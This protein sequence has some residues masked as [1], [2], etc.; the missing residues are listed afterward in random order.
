MRRLPTQ[1]VPKRAAI[2][3]STGGRDRCGGRKR[4]AGPRQRSLA[5]LF[6][7]ACLCAW[8]NL[9]IGDV[10]AQLTG[11]LGAHDPSTVLYEDGR[12][13]YF[14]TG[15]LLAV[16]SSANLNFWSGEPAALSQV[17]AW[18]PGAVPGYQ[19]QS[20]WAPDVIELGGQYYLYYSASVWGTKLS[21]IGLA[22]S[23]TLDPDAPGYGWTDQGMIINSNHGSPYNAIDPSLLLD[24]ATG[25]LWMTWGSF[26]NGIYVKEM[27]PA[28]GLPLS[29]SPGV[30][31]AAPGPTVEIEGAAM[32]KRGGYYYMFVNWGGCCSGVDSTYNIRVGRSTSPTGP[33][34]DRDGVNMLSGGGT[35]FLDD[36]GRKIAPGHFSFTDV[37]GQDQFSYHYY[38]GDAIGAPTFALRDLYWTADDWPSI[39]AVNPEWATAADGDW[40]LPSRWTN[41]V[42]PDGVGHVANFAAGAGS[43]QYLS[44]DLGGADRTVGTLNFRSVARYFIG[45]AAGPALT[46]DDVAGES[47]TINVS[48]GLPVIG[49]P[50]TALDRLEVNVTPADGELTLNGTVNGPG[51]RK[52]GDGEL[53]LAGAN[54]TFSDSIFV[55]NGS[56]V[57]TG[58]VTGN[59][60]NSIGQIL[61]ETGELSVEGTGQFISNGDLN[62]G[63]TGNNSTPATGTLYVSDQANVVVGA[64]GGLYVGSGFSANTRAE[65]AVVQT[66]G[67]LSVN[68]PA[69][70]SFIVG[71]RGSSAANG[72]YQ[73]S[74]GTVFANT[75]VFIG[76]RGQGTVDQTGGDFNASQFVAIARYAGSTGNWTIRGGAL[77][78]TNAATWLLVG[79]QGQGEL[80]LAGA[81]QV[82]ASGVVRLGHQSSGAGAINL[83]G[84]TLTA[85][86][87]VRGAGSAVVNLNGGILRA[88]GSH[89]SFLQGLT[90]VNV[91]AGGAAV[92]TQHFSVTIAQP[93]LHAAALGATPDGGLTK[94]GS[95]TLTL[96]AA[97][98]YTGPTTVAAGTLRAA[99][100]TGSATGV[101]DVF[102]ES[103]ATLSGT[104]AVAGGVTI[105]TG[106]TLA[107][108]DSPG[109]LSVGSVVL[110]PGAIFAVELAGHGGVAGVGFDQL[111][112]SGDASLAGLLSVSL[113]PGFVPTVGDSFE[114]LNVGGTR[115]G[116]FAGSGQGD[117]VGVWGSIGLLIDYAAGDGNDVALLAQ[118]LLPGDY[119]FDSDADG[120][121]FLLWQR[122]ESSTPLSPSDLA[123]WQANYGASLSFVPSNAVAEPNSLALLSVSPLMVLLVVR[124]KR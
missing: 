121:D 114:I 116:T 113:V 3:G 71:G 93:L 12:Y 38:N 63:D 60:F 112:V 94:T 49:A 115:A 58:S 82:N 33:F 70:G 108:G 99:N 18:V 46:L 67:T 11:Q 50:V 66:G 29:S 61:G 87:I 106:G 32:V 73:L 107:P 96:A 39:A 28:N 103:G 44:V 75:N 15:D 37:G 77:N 27:N 102:V 120:A 51:L 26:N 72:T 111:V 118:T 23:P 76:G 74:G 56:V 9:P 19:G 80:T 88:A 42:V 90:A 45:D 64:G 24:D 31:V 54:S 48:Q 79:E 40:S 104:G 95:G 68:R 101:G 123:N 35:L 5:V 119:D 6:W 55:K 4:S 62:I 110:T 7:L 2:P 52:Y 86:Q 47:A 8:G 81:G 92:D 36:D 41:N 57:V 25:R 13:Y 65:G 83:D 69:D 91:E 17:P 117:L 34:V 100:L 105:A 97:N 59:S 89:N 53:R 1:T 98:G 124:R 122:G 85:P 43:R 22:T 14:A 16:R 10:C 21:A 84:G 20:L 78:Q 109:I 30:N